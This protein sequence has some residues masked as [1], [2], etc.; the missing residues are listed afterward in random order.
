MLTPKMIDSDIRNNVSIQQK[1][2]Q[3]WFTTRE[4]SMNGKSAF[5]S[6]FFRN[7]RKKHTKVIQIW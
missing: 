3:K 4:P 1:K 5:S 6:I 2:N 7:E